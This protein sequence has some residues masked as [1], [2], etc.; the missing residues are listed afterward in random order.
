MY[1]NLKVFL[2]VEGIHL[3]LISEARSGNKA[4]LLS[5]NSISA[6]CETPTFSRAVTLD[7]NLYFKLPPK[8]SNPHGTSFTFTFQTNEIDGAI[9]CISSFSGKNPAVF[10]MF[11]SKRKPCIISTGSSSFN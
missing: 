2:K 3:D 10:S 1:F 9:F 11:I 4:F 5:S 7:G 8:E 6:D